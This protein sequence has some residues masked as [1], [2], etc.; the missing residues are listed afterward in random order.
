MTKTNTDERR[1]ILWQLDHRAAKCAVAYFNRKR[2]DYWLAYVDSQCQDMDAHR[3]M[4][5]WGGLQYEAALWLQETIHREW[6]VKKVV[7]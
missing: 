7:K 5:Y 4:C 3:Q 6:K 1:A 2:Q